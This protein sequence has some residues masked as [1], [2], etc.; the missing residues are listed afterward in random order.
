[1]KILFAVLFAG[2]ITIGSAQNQF[3]RKGFIFGTAFGGT[4]V[5][6]KYSNQA[7]YSEMSVSFPNFKLGGMLNKRMAVLLYL[8]GS[9]Y[10]YRDTEREHQRGFE[11]IM[12]SIQYWV[13]YRW[14]VSAGVGLAM[15][16]PAFY[17]IK[18][19]SDRKF[20]FGASTALATGYELWRKGQFIIDI[21][22]RVHYGSANINGSAR[23]GLAYTIV[24]GLNWY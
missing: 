11:A 1:M 15:D 7:D 8:P 9:L 12:P 22:G 13:K 6:L 2:I 3:E 5:N 21:Q 19:K 17:D 10:T 18:T 4:L 20:Y 23:N 14:W 16:A 24:L